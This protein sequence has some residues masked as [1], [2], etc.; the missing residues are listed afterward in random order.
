M[1]QGS[2]PEL[3]A[4]VP[5]LQVLRAYAVNK[6]LDMTDAFEEYSG[7]GYE[8]AM[9][10]MDKNRFRSTIGLLFAGSVSRDVLAAICH[11]YRA[12]HPDPGEAD[13]YTQ[14]RWKQFAI[15]FDNVRLPDNHNQLPPCDPALMRELQLLRVE[16]IKR[17]L[18]MTDAF[19][20]YAGSL[21]ER[22][23]GIMMK[24]RFRS[25]MG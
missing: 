7:T 14:V 9:G 3:R 11:A 6:K 2:P 13:G 1:Q 20:S 21:Q 24:R 12:G 19:E 8:K 17:R 5:A 4:L 15:D 16:A 25:T 18:D 22:N 10:V 23:T